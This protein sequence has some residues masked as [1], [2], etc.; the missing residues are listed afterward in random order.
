MVYAG[1]HARAGVSRPA[2]ALMPRATMPYA[3]KREREREKRDGE[4]GENKR[5]YRI[6]M[7][8]RG[9]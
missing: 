4:A 7:R 1:R 6:E 3:I 5:R 9:E 8:G 2:V